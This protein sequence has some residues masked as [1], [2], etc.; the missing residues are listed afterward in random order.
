MSYLQ[1]EN[2]LFL[3]FQELV[4]QQK[5]IK[6][7]GFIRLFQS[8]I[9]QFGIVNVDSDSAFAN[10]KIESGS[11]SGTI[12]IATDSFA[13]DF[14]LNVITQ[15]AID[16]IAVTNDSAWYWVKI[17][18]QFI[19]KEVGTIN[20]A[21]NGN[22]TGL[23]T[24]FTEVLRDQNNYSVKIC[25]PNSVLNTADYQVASILSDTLAILAGTTGFISENGLDY[26]VVGSFTP[27]IS[28]V[29]NLRFP[30]WYDG[31][32]IEFIP[33][34]NVDV[35]PV[36]TQGSEFY[37]ARV[38]NISGA[39]TVQDKRTEIL[40]VAKQNS[41]WIQ[42]TLNSGFVN[43]SGKEVKYRM[44]YLGEIEVKGVFTAT[45]GTGTLFTLPTNFC[46]YLN[47]QGFYGYN[48]GSV[49]R[50]IFA[51]TNG[52][53]KASATFPFSTTVDNVITSLRFKTA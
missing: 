5:F 33:E 52:E 1:I 3:G 40:S 37:I 47:A 4:R 42:P 20:V 8:I 6:D 46:P 17:S 16:N 25:F 12:K 18:H 45:S 38:Q 24:K 31:C 35:P 2:D 29:G 50:V 19:N 39:I 27:G 14:N 21:A 23:N 15:K 51:N 28:K 11:N 10:F 34:V 53:V 9:N 44:N 13:V 48:D 41:G 22:I 49:I 7:D 43:V 32:L 26:Q 36:K 30:Y